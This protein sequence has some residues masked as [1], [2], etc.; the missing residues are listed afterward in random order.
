[1]IVEPQPYSLLTVWRFR[2]RQAFAWYSHTVLSKPVGMLFA[3][4]GIILVRAGNTR[5]GLGWVLKGRRIAE[6]VAADS[7]LRRFIE[8]RPDAGEVFLSMI[9]ASAK[10]GVDKNTGR[11]LI[12]KTPRLDG[13]RVVEK[14]AIV[15]K[16]T[17]TF[18]PFFCS[19]DARR[20]ARYFRIILEPS[21]VGYSLPAILLW[22]KL[23]PE[24]VIVMAPYGPD[25]RLLE[26]LDSNLV[27]V[28]LGPADWVSP[29]NFHKLPDL[30]KKYDCIY[31][32]NYKATKRVD[33]YV[34]AVVRVSRRRPGFRAALFCVG[35][36]KSFYGPRVRATIEWARANGNLD[37]LAGVKQPQLNAFL[38]QSKVNVLASLREGANKGLAEGLFAG[39]PALLIR[40]S[41]CGNH[42]HIN[43]HTG[44]VV[45]DRELEAALEW[46]ADH[47][48]QFSPGDWALKNI[49]PD[50]SARRLSE[51][52]KTLDVSEG[53]EWTSDLFVKV[54]RPEMHYLDSSIEWLKHHRPELL[55]AFEAGADETGVQVFLTALRPAP[56]GLAVL[57]GSPAS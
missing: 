9:P 1:M 36:G 14:G 22:T 56:D 51:I 35:V 38:N 37:F 5:L 29:E 41:A 47:H 42:L 4:A 17:E 46:F 32:A 31:I 45:P 16:F 6:V 50:V 39:T 25:F 57:A 34:R 3:W 10:S 18:T 19:V 15:I 33:R 30:E 48:E 55:K 52:L 26:R 8:T 11:F 28:T 21:W 23:A 40:E 7:F 2:V 49:A 20:L 53:Y 43:E 24:K 44:K 13:K 12:L 54:N 27:P